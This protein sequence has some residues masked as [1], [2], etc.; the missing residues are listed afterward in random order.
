MAKKRFIAGAICQ[1][2]G[3]QD[4][5]RAWED[6][7]QGVMRRQCNS[8][9]YQDVIALE[10]DNPAELPTRV[11]Y[12]DPVFDQDVKPVRLVISDPKLNS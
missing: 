11:N 5:I 10:L 12:S 6:R 8:C 4:K 9:D 2:C 1:N 3:A 7:E